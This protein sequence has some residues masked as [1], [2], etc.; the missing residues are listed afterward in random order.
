MEFP[1]VFKL[2]SIA[3]NNE[4]STY[5]PGKRF[6]ERFLSDFK[7]PSFFPHTQFT[8]VID[9]TDIKYLKLVAVLICSS[10]KVMIDWPGEETPF[11]D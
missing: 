11:K 9:L 2:A 8:Q 7:F 10:I 4:L 3:S 6:D 1:G 5:S